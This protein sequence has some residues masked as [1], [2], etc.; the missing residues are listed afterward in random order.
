MKHLEF[1]SNNFEEEKIFST[2]GWLRN[3][4]ERFNFTKKKQ[5]PKNNHVWTR[6]KSHQ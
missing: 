3:L 5:Y 2:L 6:I 1:C 4:Q